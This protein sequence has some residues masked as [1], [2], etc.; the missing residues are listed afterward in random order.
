MMHTSNEFN[1][2]LDLLYCPRS[3]FFSFS[4]DCVERCETCP[5]YVTLHG[6]TD[7]CR[8]LLCV[9]LC[10]VSFV[11]NCTLYQLN[12][13]G[14]LLSFVVSSF[15]YSWYKLKWPICSQPS[16]WKVCVDNWSFTSDALNT[17]RQE[18][19]EQTFTSQSLSLFPLSI[20]M[21]SIHLGTY[22]FWLH[23]QI[24]PVSPI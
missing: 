18:I 17:S 19:E 5:L 6:G 20:L 24:A 4:S 8:C 7:C 23:G 16:L 15:L 21:E 1:A 12:K 3:P 14:T 9:L 10:L 2:V 13:N 11:H 22:L